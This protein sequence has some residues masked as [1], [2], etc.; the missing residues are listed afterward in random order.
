MFGSSGSKDQANFSLRLARMMM[1]FGETEIPCGLRSINNAF[2]I[3]ILIYNYTEQ[4]LKYCFEIS[5]YPNE[6]CQC[7]AY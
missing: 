5:T 3:G 4:P 7:G 1:V 2:R 6:K